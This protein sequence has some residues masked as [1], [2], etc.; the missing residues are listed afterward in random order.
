MTA[1]T[2]RAAMEDPAYTRN[3]DIVWQ[4]EMPFLLR[5]AQARRAAIPPA[6]TIPLESL[7]AV[8]R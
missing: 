8:C 1:I 6:P 2:L 4:G 3:D 5:V 7:N